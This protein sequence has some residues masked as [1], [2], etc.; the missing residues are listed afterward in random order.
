M[1]L[2]VLCP[3][4]DEGGRPA[5]GHNEAE[6]DYDLWP[7]EPGSAD[8]QRQCERDYGNEIPGHCLAIGAAG[9]EREPVPLAEDG[10]ERVLPDAE[11]LVELALR[12]DEGHE[13]ADAVRVDP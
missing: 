9:R 8:G 5:A 2:G 11:C 6:A 10:A 1:T 4:G 13:H 3:A 7:A 12:D